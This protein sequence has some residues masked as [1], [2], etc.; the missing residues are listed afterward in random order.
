MAIYKAVVSITVLADT[1]S[2]EDL[3]AKLSDMSLSQIDYEIR[4]GEWLGKSETTYTLVAP[5]DLEAE[6]ESVD[7]S[8]DF[9]DDKAAADDDR[10]A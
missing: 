7:G 9:F 2:E 4:D 10:P 5:Q 3:G 6:C 1:E 8:P